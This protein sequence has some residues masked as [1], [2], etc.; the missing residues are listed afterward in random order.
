MAPSDKRFLLVIA[1]SKRKLETAHPISALDR[2]D[3]GTYRTIRKLER[4]H[5]LP[6]SVD[7]KIISA[8]YGLIDARR[9][10]PYYEQKLTAERAQ[11]LKDSIIT[12]L[13]KCVGDVNYEEI[14]FDLGTDYLAPI[15]SFVQ[16]VKCKTVVASGRIG[17]R[18]RSVKTWLLSLGAVRPS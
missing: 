3:G 7:I 16:S 13:R 6:Q 2:Y 4:E 10:I 14:Y 17:I 8:K 15:E 18:L 1:C 11:E 5:K 9:K 12:S